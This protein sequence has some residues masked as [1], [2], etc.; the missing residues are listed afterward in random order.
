MDAILGID[1]SKKELYYA[2]FVKGKTMQKKFANS[3][4]GFNQLAKWLQTNKVNKVKA[5][6][7]A[8]GSYGEKLADFLYES[9][10]EVHVVNPA[11]IKAFASSK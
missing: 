6:M 9:G 5:C 4:Q 3:L 8:T 2:L 10:H 1:I 7:E 11:C